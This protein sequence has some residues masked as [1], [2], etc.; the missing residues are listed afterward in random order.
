[1]REDTSWKS[2]T[3]RFQTGSGQSSRSPMPTHSEER[4][5]VRK[6]ERRRTNKA[7]ARTVIRGRT[8]ASLVFYCVSRVPARVAPYESYVV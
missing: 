1:M 2:F 4:G 3:E 8:L 7:C 6:K 5:E